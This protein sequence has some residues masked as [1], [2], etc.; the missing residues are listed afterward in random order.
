[1]TPVAMLEGY[2]TVWQL[3]MLA[4]TPVIKRSQ[5]MTP[6]A[7]LQ[8]MLRSTIAHTSK[9]STRLSGQSS[10]VTCLSAD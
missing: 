7:M 6:V 8:R 9:V 10:L 2:C 3:K 1:M 5:P 4:V